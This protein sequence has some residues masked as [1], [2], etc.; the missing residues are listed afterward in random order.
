MNTK[1]YEFCQNNSGGNFHVDNNICH[2]LFIEAKNATQANDI[3]QYLGVYFDGCAK[4]MD[5]YCCGDRWHEADTHSSIDLEEVSKA[6]KI[7]FTT[8]E[9]YAQYLVNEYGWTMPDARIFYL[10][11]KVVEIKKGE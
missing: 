6:F 10:S 2:Q 1:F 11:G 7:P 8:I 9:E 4:G 5:C 3:A